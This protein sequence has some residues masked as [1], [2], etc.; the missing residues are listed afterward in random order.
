MLFRWFCARRKLRKAIKREHAMKIVRRLVVRYLARFR[1]QWNRKR[2][3]QTFS[4][5]LINAKHLIGVDDLRANVYVYTMSCIDKAGLSKELRL[6]ILRTATPHQL[7]P[8]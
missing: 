5:D 4:L 2:K 6:G 3:P 8:A 7:L 1:K